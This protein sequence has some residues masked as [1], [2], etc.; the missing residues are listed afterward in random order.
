MQLT[1]NSLEVGLLSTLIGLVVGFLSN[2][3]I[4]RLNAR[5]ELIRSISDKRADAYVALWK[6]CNG[7]DLGNR[8]ARIERHG[9]LNEWYANGGGLF[10]RFAATNRLMSAIRILGRAEQGDASD[11]ELADLAHNL[12]WLRTEMKYAVGSYSR[13]EAKRQIPFTLP[14]RKAQDRQRPIQNRATAEPDREGEAQV[15]RT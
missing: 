14:P 10:L 11:A 2:Y 12:S 8:A 13:L 4:A 5:S 7:R 3:V 1:N 9:Q 6:L 15:E